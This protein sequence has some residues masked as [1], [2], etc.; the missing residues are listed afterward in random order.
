M[1]NIYNGCLIGL[2]I[3]DALGAPVEFLSLHEIQSHYGEAGITTFEEWDG[4]KP[5]SYTD[6][7]QMSLATAL[8]C[9]RAHQMILSRRECSGTEEVYKQY[10]R[11]LAS[12]EDPELLRYPGG[13]CLSALRSGDRGSIETPINDSK[14]CGGVMRTAPV[15][16]AFP[17]HMAFREGADYAALTHGHPSGYLPGGFLAE[18]TAHIVEGRALRDALELS[19]ESLVRYADH[20]ETLYG[21]ERAMKLAFSFENPISAIPKLG[22]G[23]VGNETLSIAVYCSLKFAYDFRL[24]VLASINHSGDSDSTGAVTGAILGAVLGDS[25]IPKPWIMRL[26]NSYH[27]SQIAMDMYKTFQ[28]GERLSSEKYLSD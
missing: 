18:L 7:T 19:I 3:G 9:I 22:E 14:G 26:E 17:S 20:S 11:W 6:D 12:Q 5:G 16:L 27:I 25:A 1:I 15:G 23:W 2:A 10:L 4:R 21:V 8:G 13:T 28:R 24:G